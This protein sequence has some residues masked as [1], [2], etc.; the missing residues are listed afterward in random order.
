[1]VSVTLPSGEIMANGPPL[2]SPIMHVM[3]TVR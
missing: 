3:A 2:D 1:M